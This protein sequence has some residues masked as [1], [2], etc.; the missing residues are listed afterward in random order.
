MLAVVLLV[1]AAA[2]ESQPDWTTTRRLVDAPAYVLPPGPVSFEAR[3]LGAPVSGS[4]TTFL[5]GVLDAGLPGR[6]DL[7]VSADAFFFLLLPGGLR[8]AQNMPAVRLRWGVLPWGLPVNPTLGLVGLHGSL[9]G[10]SCCDDWAVGPELGLSG[11]LLESRMHWSLLGQ[12]AF[13]VAP[14]TAGV[15]P[16]VSLGVIGAFT[17]HLGVGLSGSMRWLVP[18]PLGAGA[19]P[20]PDWT[21]A[22]HGS[23]G[24]IVQLRLFSSFRAELMLGLFERGAVDDESVS[25]TQVPSVRLTLAQTVDFVSAPK[26]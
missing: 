2:P 22:L 10:F 16:A 3:A 5:H 20:K 24:L 19:S 13:P 23:L 1:L 11:T 18:A 9:A 14:A 4:V 26:R 7:A 15:Q 12:V 6:L 25:G 17:E 8:P 21:L